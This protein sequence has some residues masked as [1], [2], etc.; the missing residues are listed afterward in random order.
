MA[1]SH[2]LR[3]LC[4][5]AV[6]S[7]PAL[8][9]VAQAVAM[10][11]PTPLP[12]QEIVHVVTA[13]RSDETLHNATRTTYV[14]GRDEI[15][16]RGYRTIGD[17]LAQLPGVQITR[18]GPIGQNVSYGI[19][20]SSSSQVLVLVDG[21]PAPGEFANSVQLGTQSTAGVRRIE[22]V[23]GGGSTLYGSGA[24]GGIINVITDAQ[25]ERPSGTARYGTFGDRELR[26]SAHGVSFERIVANNTFAVPASPGSPSTR[27]NSDDESTSLH[28]GLD[29]KIGAVEATFRSG[30]ENDHLG[31]AGFYPFLSAS[32]REDDVNASGS[33]AFSLVRPQ[34]SATLQIGGSRQQLAFACNAAGDANC[35][36]AV[37]ALNTES[38]L[39]FSLRNAVTS[40]TDRVLYGMDFSRGS[41]R[42]DSGAGTAGSIAT[43]TL[44]QSAA[45]AQET[46][47]V[48]AGEAYV[49][50]RA[51]R[52][53]SLGGEFSP[54]L[55]F[56]TPFGHTLEVKLNAASAFRAPNA[57]ELYFPGYGNPGLAP[58]RAQLADVSLAANRISGGVSAGWFTNRTTDLIVPQMVGTDGSGN[59]IFKPENVHHA[60]LQGFTLDARTLPL[61]G[62]TA[63]LTITDLYRAQ[64]VDA[65]SR[66]PNDPV[67]TVNFSL[68]VRGSAGSRF[69]D[70]G[71]VLR[72]VGA[73]SSV[74]PLQ[75][76]FAQAAAY[77]NFDAYARFRIAPSALVALRG[78]NLGNERYAEVAGF[79]MPGR[80]FAAEISIR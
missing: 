29:R 53:G 60:R 50:V 40:R 42:E 63:A 24:I 7:A 72:S 36:S 12:P 39:G 28:F 46:R 20:G 4:A 35:F 15:V 13:D 69:V 62:I 33:A 34:A 45:Y 38:R 18:Y 11:S 80:T 2:R 21:M 75:P 57:S 9:A 6:F 59:P 41:V 37:P 58:E 73:R 52:D 43:A 5:A 47:A 23:E 79:P 14:V 55:G 27:D 65:G 49:G 74:N 68:G 71:I 31:A 25:F 70:G 54:A 26:L 3:A 32:S 77:S 17:A 64:D 78:Y 22:V 56:R 67:F 30:I 8:P 1:N 10:P 66:L 44:S 51:E 48:G 61:H 16:R 76:L 19:R